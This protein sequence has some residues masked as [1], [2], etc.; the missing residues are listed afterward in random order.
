MFDRY[1][2]PDLGYRIWALFAEMLEL[3]LAST[4]K[5]RGKC[6]RVIFIH[7]VRKSMAYIQY[8]YN[9]VHGIYTVHVQYMYNLG[10]RE[11]YWDNKFRSVIM[12]YMWCSING[13]KMSNNANNGKYYLKY[14]SSLVIYLHIVI[15]STDNR[16]Y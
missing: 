1:F 8:M 14:C 4:S 9:T 7:S 11:L 6:S 16:N 15:D 10:A 13:K 2:S 12:P 5:I 3:Q